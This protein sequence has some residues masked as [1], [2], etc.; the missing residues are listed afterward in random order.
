MERM[1]E[2][3]DWR[4]GI[5]LAAEIGGL[6]VSSTVLAAITELRQL[7]RRFAALPY[8]TDVLGFVLAVRV[9]GDVKEYHFE[10]TDAIRRNKK[11]KYIR[12]DIG[13]PAERWK[14]LSSDHFR[15]YLFRGMQDALVSC[16]ERLKKD[17]VEV[18]LKRLEADLAKVE[19]R[20]LH[21]E[22]HRRSFTN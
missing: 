1:N 4:R 7:L 16:V 19:A 15:A 22:S 11:G 20:F 6:Q 3:N 8:S 21:Q 12:A 9:D 2:P 17:R 18:D 14:V 13:I 10:G 5:S